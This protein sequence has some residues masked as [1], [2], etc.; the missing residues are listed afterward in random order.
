MTKTVQVGRLHPSV[1]AKAATASG[2]VQMLA[3]VFKCYRINLV[4]PFDGAATRPRDEFAQVTLVK[5]DTP[6]WAT[7]TIKMTQ[8]A[9]AKVQQTGFRAS[10]L[11]LGKANWHGFD[12]SIDVVGAHLQTDWAYRW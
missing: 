4:D 2:F 5:A 6:V 12:L 7:S 1:A 3:V 11:R 8:V 10:S 9:R